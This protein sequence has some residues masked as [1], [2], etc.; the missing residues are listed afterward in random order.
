MTTETLEGSTSDLGTPAVEVVGVS[1]RFEAIQALRD[2]SVSFYAGEVHALVG[3]NGAGKSTLVKVLAGAHRCDD[4]VVR[5]KGDELGLGSPKDAI[6]A[7]I[8]VVYQELTLLP[9]MTVE[10]NLM[11]GREPRA[12]VGWLDR[13]TSAEQ[14]ERFLAIVGGDIDRRT[15]VDRLSIAQ[16]QLLEIARALSL[17]A[18]VLLLDEPTSSLSIQEV[19]H[20]RTRDR[21]P[22]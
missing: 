18:E 7:G 2:V 15:T 17:R 1:K 9:S 21:E 11:L 13:K 4:G 3:E 22:A 12:A 14:A 6:S 20:L 16:R 8:A 10:E 5:R 19:D